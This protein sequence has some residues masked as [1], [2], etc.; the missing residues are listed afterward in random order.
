MFSKVERKRK[1]L[2][3][4]D[5]RFRK[6][7][8][9]RLNKADR[10]YYWANRESELARNKAY[11]DVYYPKNRKR[12]KETRRNRRH[13][14]TQDWFD[15]QLKKQNNRC[16]ICRCLF[17]KTP[18]IDHDHRCCPPERS[19]DKCR[20]GILCED[21]NLGLGR[22]KEN[23]KALKRAIQYLRRHNGLVNKSGI[24]KS[25]R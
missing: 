8:K 24:Q 3:E 20:R 23:I 4:A 1:Q 12:L 10:E 5:R 17:E 14:I 25:S 19:C 18:H 16:A 7:H 22:F 21:C 6:K 2:R 11:Y 9:K 13:G 15:R